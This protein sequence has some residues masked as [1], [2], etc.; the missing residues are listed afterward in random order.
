MSVLVEPIGAALFVVVRPLTVHCITTANMD[1]TL[2]R[3]EQQTRGAY[4]LKRQTV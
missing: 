2:R 4:G 1:N 3:P